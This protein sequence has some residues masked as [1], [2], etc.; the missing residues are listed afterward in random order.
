MNKKKV[1]YPFKEVLSIGFSLRFIPAS[2]S[3][4]SWPGLPGRRYCISMVPFW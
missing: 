1:E 2:T 4:L 3:H